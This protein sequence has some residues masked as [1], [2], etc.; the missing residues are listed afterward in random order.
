MPIFQRIVVATDFSEASSGAV[1]LACAIAAEASAQL[2]VLNVCDVPGYV[3]TGP[4]PYDLATAF[5][6]TAQAHLDALLS[7]IRKTCPGARALVRIG[8]PWQEIL[9]VAAESRAD[10]IVIGTH[11][12][13]GV[14]H[15]V[16]G[17]V[18]EHV[19]RASPVPV[20]TVRNGAAVL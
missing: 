1:R 18:A 8:V 19:V 13:R 6:A 7:P 11:G 10:L 5:V 16:L 4:I 17:S 15:A 9:A 20:L 2:T 12:R 14:A 3:D